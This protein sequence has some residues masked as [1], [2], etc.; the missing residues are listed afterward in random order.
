MKFLIYLIFWEYTDQGSQ[1]M[2]SG[3]TIP[4]STTEIRG[5]LRRTLMP[6]PRKSPGKPPPHSPHPPQ[7]TA[8]PRARVRTYPHTHSRHDNFHH[9]RIH[10]AVWLWITTSLSSS[11]REVSNND[12][13]RPLLPK[14]PKLLKP[15][16]IMCRTTHILNTLCNRLI[17]RPITS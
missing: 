14:H 11:V 5:L 13:D 7:N 1:H 9:I 10:D 6:Q 2:F 3:Y 4:G 8:R 17:V 12:S 15:I 16:K